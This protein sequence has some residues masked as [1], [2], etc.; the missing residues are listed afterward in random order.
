MLSSNTQQSVIQY[1]QSEYL[2]AVKDARAAKQ[3]EIPKDLLAI[4]P[5]FV[6]IIQ[7]VQPLN[8]RYAF[9]WF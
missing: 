7:H 5:A 3:N 4:V 6:C 9:L 8:I 2:Q 1:L